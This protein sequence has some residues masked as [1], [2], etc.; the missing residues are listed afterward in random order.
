MA[1]L[2]QIPEPMRSAIAGLEC[3]RFETLPW[4]EGPP[5]TRRRVAIVSTA[6]LHRRDDRPFVFA[7]SDYRIIPGDISANDLVMSHV[8]T[9]FDRTG[10]QQDW[11]VVFPL[12]RLRELAQQ[13]VIG[14]IADFHYSFMGAT[15]PGQM[16]PMATHLA[17][18][19]KKDQVNAIFL[20]PV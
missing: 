18:L 7:A 5:L 3:P 2:D 20:V 11:N 10:F 13:G 4:V 17:D 14:S 8:S 16:E 9:N 6:G 15:D 19:L 12:D 1:R